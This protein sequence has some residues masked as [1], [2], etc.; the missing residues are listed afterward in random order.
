MQ[1]IN[2]QYPNG[3]IVEFVSDEIEIKNEEDANRVVEELFSSGSNKVIL[4]KKNLSEN[5]FELKTGLAGAILQ[6]FVNYQIRAAIVGD[7][8]NIT[9]KSLNA[10]IFESN[11]GDQINFLKDVETAIQKLRDE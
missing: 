10:F 1:L 6:K 8:K 5:F 11:R 7:F 2:H 3:S 4:H 9:S